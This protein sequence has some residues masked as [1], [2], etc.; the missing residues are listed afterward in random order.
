GIRHGPFPDTLTKKQVEGIETI[1]DATPPDLDPRALAYILATA[2]WETGRTME[3][4]QERGSKA[5]LRSKKYWPW[6]GR[7]YVQLTWKG[8][9]DRY[10]APVLEHYGVDIVK[11]PNNAMI[12]K[13]A[14]FI[15]V[16]GMLRGAFTGTGLSHYFNDH[17]S[18]W[19][20][21]RQII[22]RLDKASEI[23]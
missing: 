22:N 23:A 9:Y 19:V 14:A 21:A 12:P 3:P 10:R 2:F 17:T 13:V 6:I 8:N 7:G 4:I 18:D 16:D 1:L 15:L 5:Y 20:H 11:D